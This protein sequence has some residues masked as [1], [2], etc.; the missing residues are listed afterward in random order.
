MDRLLRHAGQHGRGGVT[1]RRVRFAPH[2]DPPPRPLAIGEHPGL[3]PPDSSS[4]A[5]DR[6]G[7]NIEPAS[8]SQAAIGGQLR[9]GNSFLKL[10]RRRLRL[11]AHRW[12]TYRLPNACR[13]T[14]TAAERPRLDVWRETLRRP[15]SNSICA[16]WRRT[17][18]ASPKA[19][20]TPFLRSLPADDLIDAQMVGRPLPS[21]GHGEGPPVCQ[22]DVRW[23]EQCYTAHASNVRRI[24]G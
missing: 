18:S 2:D 22:R 16:I 17:S 10:A 4:G 6:S 8:G 1:R 5:R 24:V 12:T 13:R 14:T 19:S 3:R 21:L 15:R 9:A 7:R 20:M 11:D 23:R